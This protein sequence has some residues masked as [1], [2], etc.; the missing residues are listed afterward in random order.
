MLF[1]PAEINRTSIRGKRLLAILS[2]LTVLLTFLPFVLLIVAPEHAKWMKVMW[3]VAATCPAAWAGPAM[4]D[5][6]QARAASFSA[7]V[8]FAGVV[9]L[10]S[11][12][13]SSQKA[14]FSP[15]SKS[16]TGLPSPEATESPIERITKS[17]IGAIVAVVVSDLLKPKGPV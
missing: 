3:L 5:R 7:S 11:E 14:E 12:P 10:K 15:R 6:W 8:G 1:A 4:I 16:M 9:K 17:P 13:R 2:W